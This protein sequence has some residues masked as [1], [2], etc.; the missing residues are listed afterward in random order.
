MSVG[1]HAQPG[2]FSPKWE[3]ALPYGRPFLPIYVHV[4]S[5]LPFGRIQWE[6][7]ASLTQS[8]PQNCLTEKHRGMEHHNELLI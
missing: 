2:R 5:D 6:K 8:Q 3:T 4:E 1:A 7:W